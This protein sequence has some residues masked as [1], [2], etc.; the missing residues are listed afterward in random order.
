PGREMQ[1]DQP[2]VAPPEQRADLAEL[3]RHG[4][5]VTDLGRETVS[6]GNRRGRVTTSAIEDRHGGPS[7]EGARDAGPGR[8]VR[9][10]PGDHK[11]RRGIRG[12]VDVDGHPAAVDVHTLLNQLLHNDDY[13]A[14]ALEWANDARIR[15]TPAII[16][17]RRGPAP[18]RAPL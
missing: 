15:R 9:H 18:G 7:R 3:S 16:R 17:P 11:D 13:G 14:T 10:H 1:R 5:G 8:R 2:A 4:G 6:V 12:S